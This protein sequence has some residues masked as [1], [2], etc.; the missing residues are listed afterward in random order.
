MRLTLRQRLLTS[1]LI[2]ALI[3]EASMVAAPVLAASPHFIKTPTITKNASLTNIE[4]NRTD[5]SNSLIGKQFDSKELSNI[6]LVRAEK[7]P[8]IAFVE[9]TFTYAAYQN[10][11]FY[12]F[13]TKYNQITPVGAIVKSDL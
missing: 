6:N 11:S 7:G 13:Y 8:R 9:P 1:S 12:N 3:L 5:S 4:K 10:N 2:L